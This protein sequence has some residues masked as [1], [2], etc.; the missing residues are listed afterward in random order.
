MALLRLETEP[1]I[2]SPLAVVAATAPFID[3]SGMPLIVL[4][5]Y[6]IVFSLWRHRPILLAINY[7]VCKIVKY[8]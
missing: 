3:I 1:R 6:I 7:F 2:T 8:K 5:H 4:G